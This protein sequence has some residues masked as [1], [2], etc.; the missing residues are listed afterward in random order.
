MKIIL[1]L[2]LL[3]ITLLVSGCGYDSYT[4]CKLKESQKCNRESCVDAARDYCWK[5]VRWTNIECIKDH[6]ET[7]SN[8]EFSK[9]ACAHVK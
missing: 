4:E 6:V 7:G 8:W 5:K 1:P 9:R 2:V 3:S